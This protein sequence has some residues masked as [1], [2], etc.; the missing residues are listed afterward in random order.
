[1]LGDIVG[2]GVERD[3][4]VVLERVPPLR[5][6]GSPTVAEAIRRGDAD[7]AVSTRC[8]P[9]EDVTWI[10]ADVT[11]GDADELAPLRRAAV[12]AARAVIDA[13]RAGDAALSIDALGAFRVLCAHRRGAHG[14]ATWTDRIERWL[15]AEVGGFGTEGRWYAGRPLL[16]TENDYG[17]RLYNGDT[18]VVV[19]TGP[20]TV[21]A[22][23]ERRGEVV[24]SSPTRLRRGRHRLRDDGPQEP[25][26]AVR[27]R[28]PSCCPRR[29]R[30]SSRASCSTP[31]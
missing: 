15:A 24:E 1:M 22:A 30:R 18:G 7:G 20:G 6:A 16:V 3:G 14:V 31:P 12:D 2:A 5:R 28:R 27:R 9:S 13:A 11:D 10:E 8:A 19:A 4:I 17:L 25:G 26:L 29:R 23:F 21:T